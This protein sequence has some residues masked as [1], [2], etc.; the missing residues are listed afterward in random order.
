MDQREDAT[1]PPEPFWFRSGFRMGLWLL[2]VMWFNANGAQLG[3]A[4]RDKDT[5]E[6]IVG[7]SLPIVALSW[8]TFVG[9]RNW[10]RRQA[11]GLRRESAPVSDIRRFEGRRFRGN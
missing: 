3:R 5:S 2:V 4:L 8:D 11:R 9:I 10:R 6:V 7:L 1:E